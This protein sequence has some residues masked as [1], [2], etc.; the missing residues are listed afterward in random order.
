M[1]YPLTDGLWTGGGGATGIPDPHGQFEAAAYVYRCVARHLAVA[2]V[3]LARDPSL[4]PERAARFALAESRFRAL[5]DHDGIS[6]N[7][8]ETVATPVV[9][10][11]DGTSVPMTDLLL[12]ACESTRFPLPYRS[13]DTEL[14]HAAKELL[15]GLSWHLPDEA[16]DAIA[17]FDGG[18]R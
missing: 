7:E 9:R 5:T 11:G 15:S 16:V 8:R 1:I 12:G 14:V 4:S 10:L 3:E 2:A 17:G 18:P 13:I 6:W